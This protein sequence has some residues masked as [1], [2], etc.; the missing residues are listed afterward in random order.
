MSSYFKHFPLVDYP[1][2]GFVKNI[3]A[4]AKININPEYL[5]NFEL[6]THLRPDQIADRYYGDQGLDWSVYF[7]NDI[8]DPYYQFYI[9]DDTLNDILIEKHGSLEIAAQDIRFWQTNWR[10][11]TDP[12]SSAAYG[13]LPADVKP[14]FNAQTGANGIVAEYRRKRKTIIKHTNLIV[15][16]E[17]TTPLALVPGTIV[18]LGASVGRGTVVSNTATEILVQHIIGAWNV[19]LVNGVSSTVLQKTNSISDTEAPYYQPVTAY[20]V[21]VQTNDRR[22]KIKLIGSNY[23]ETLKKELKRTLR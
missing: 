5:T 4:R 13:S 3:A 2:V 12:I 9:P 16:Y 23:A 14:L 18:T 21:A 1:G 15:R 7:A 20:D 6:T 10:I 17:T 19:G 8:V 22:R 11:D